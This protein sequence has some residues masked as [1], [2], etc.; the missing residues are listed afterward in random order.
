M[1]YTFTVNAIR[2]HFVYTFAS[3]RFVFFSSFRCNDLAAHLHLA[4]K[5][6]ANCNTFERGERV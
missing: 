2:I 3:K 1:N 6:H 4:G 5:T